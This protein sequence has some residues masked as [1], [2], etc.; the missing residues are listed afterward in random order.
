MPNPINTSWW[1]FALAEE[2]HNFS[3]N[4]ALKIEIFVLCAEKEI[5][6]LVF[7]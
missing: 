4:G 6:L 1:L 3:G 5:N 7:I 2:R